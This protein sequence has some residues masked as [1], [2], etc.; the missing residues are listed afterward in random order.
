MLPEAFSSDT[1][2][3]ARFEHEA[4]S[5]ASLNYPN[6]TAIRPVHESDGV[7]FLSI[8]FVP[9]EDLSLRIS[10]GSIPLGKALEIMRQIATAL[11]AAHNNGIVHRDLK[12][13]P[14]KNSIGRTKLV[15]L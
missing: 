5:L 1:E 4:N 12:P 6:I 2:R 3:L 14:T 13:V 8:E 15:F 11:E 10:S 7:R 9:G